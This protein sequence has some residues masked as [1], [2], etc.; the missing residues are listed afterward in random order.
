LA[1]AFSAG[2]DLPILNPLAARYREVVDTWRVLC[3]QDE[4]STRYIEAYANYQTAPA[5]AAS[6]SKPKTAAAGAAASDDAASALAKLVITGNKGDVPAVVEAMLDDTDALS[7]ID[8][9]LIPALDE[10]GRR[11]E[12]GTFFLPQLMAASEAAKAGFDV[13]R[14]RTPAAEAVRGPIAVATVKGD[15]HD[16]GKNIVKM[17]L[18]NYGYAVIDLGRDVEPQA[19]LDCVRAH[20]VKIVGLSA[21]MT[22]TV[23]GM[24]ETIDLLHAHTP[25]VKIMVGGA[26]LNAEYAQMVGADFYAKDAAE[27][28]KFAAQVLG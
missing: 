8:D 20:D 2:L 9:H 15:I 6:S 18:E 24:K 13:I 16:I 3:G 14:E 26:V 7:V 10:V 17:L 5:S 22:S 27:S 19:V 25:Q 11:F 21:L 1:A 23:T 28:A 4:G 12:A